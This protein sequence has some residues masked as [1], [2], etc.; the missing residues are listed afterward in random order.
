MENAGYEILLGQLQNTINSVG[1][2]IPE[3]ILIIGLVILIIADLIIKE[4][5]KILIPIIALA[6]LVSSL[7]TV[8]SQWGMPS[9]LLYENMLRL[10]NYAVFFKVL[11]LLGAI[12]TVSTLGFSTDNRKSFNDNEGYTFLIGITLGLQIM[13]MAHN[14]L[15]I[16]ISVE[17]VSLCSFVLVSFTFDKKAAE[18]NLKYIFF[19]GLSGAV[20]LYGMSFIYGISGDLNLPSLALVPWESNPMYGVIVIFTIAGLLFK[21]SAFPFHLWAPDTYETA[22]SPLIAFMS[23]ATKAAAFAILIK[24]IFFVNSFYLLAIPLALIA[25]CSIGIGNFS[26]L[27][28]SN[29]KRML[30]YSSIAH[31]GFILSAAIVN[32][33]LSLEACLFYLAVYL[34]MNFAAFLLVDILSNAGGG[35]EVENFK[36][37]GFKL[38]FTG[39]IFTITMIALTGLPPTAGFYAKIFTFSSLWEAYQTTGQNIVMYLLVFGVLNSVVSLF[40]YL[41]IPYYMYFKSSQNELILKPSRSSQI[42]V[43][44]IALP[45]L[46]IFFKPEIITQYITLI[47]F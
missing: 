3:I 27:I 10:D 12:I 34:P 21:I 23:V 43:A 25:F 5:N 9:I 24:F 26:A 36:G 6:I 20:M 39:V 45:L 32:S 41:K 29:P 38:P 2:F 14:L 4:S 18:S 42:V 40:Y 37:L 30:A 35:K 7:A 31:A 46:V 16:Y 15:M 8:F 13:S 22:P 33:K 1:Y 17:L 28:Q 19:G 44:I 11:F 47:K